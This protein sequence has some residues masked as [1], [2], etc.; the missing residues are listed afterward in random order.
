MSGRRSAAMDQ[1]I[2]LVLGGMPGHRAAQVAGLH[3]SSVQRACKKA[4]IKLP[5]PKGNFRRGK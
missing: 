4:N 3:Y 2:L 1:A 5:G